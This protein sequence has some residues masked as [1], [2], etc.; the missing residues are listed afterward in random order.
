MGYSKKNY[1]F[2]MSVL[3]QKQ[4]NRLLK[5]HESFLLSKQKKK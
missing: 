2:L 1:D 3:P 4:A 5:S